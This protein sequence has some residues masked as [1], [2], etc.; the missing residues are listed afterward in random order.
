MKIIKLNAIDSTNTYLKEA[1]KNVTLEDGIV[2]VTN[3]QT[4]GRGQMGAKWQSKEGLSLSFSVFKRFDA[5]SI[6]EQSC[7]SFVVSVGVKNALQKLQIPEVSIKWPND[8]LSYQK[9]LCGILIEN[10]L[11]GNKIISSVI[12]IGL[13][14]NE[15]EFQELP[16]ATSMKLASGNS[17]NLDEVLQIVF[18]EVLKELLSVENSETL[19]VKKKYE[20]DLFR[21][22]RVSVFENS[23]GYQFNGIIRG[24]TNTGKLKVEIENETIQVYGLKEIKML[25]S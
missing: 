8:I 22:D 5:L 9:K 11:E 16:F 20:A 7:I 13:N 19:S 15:T 2:V 10:Q 3:K 1:S 17:Y 18:E 25:F 23:E 4:E 24:I 6:N 21:I 14:V 12:G